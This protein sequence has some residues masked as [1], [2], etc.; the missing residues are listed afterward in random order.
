MGNRAEQEVFRARIAP[1]K[2]RIEGRRT[3]RPS[4]LTVA[5]VVRQGIVFPN[6]PK[7]L[8]VLKREVQ[9]LFH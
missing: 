5:T 4:K 3:A 2:D 7:G 9:P 6:F 8:H 1:S